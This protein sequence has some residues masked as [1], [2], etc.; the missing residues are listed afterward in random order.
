ML[1]NEAIQSNEQ[2]I[3]MINETL[4]TKRDAVINIFNDKLTIA[5]SINMMLTQKMLKKIMMM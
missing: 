1:F 5:V 2:M 3:K 4:L